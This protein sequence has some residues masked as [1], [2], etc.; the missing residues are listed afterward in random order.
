MGKTILVTGKEGFLGNEISQHFLNQGCQVAA[1]VPPRKESF[2]SVDQD[3]RLLQ[4]PWTRRSAVAAKNFVLRTLQEFES[5]DEAWIVVTPERESFGIAELAPL[6]LDEGLDGTVKG[7]LYLVRELLQRQA[8]HP[9][10]VLRFVFY[11]EDPSTLPPLAAL[12]YQ[13]LRGM[14]TAL[15]TQARKRSLTVWAYETLVPRTEEYLA[16]ILTSKTPQPGRWNV[17]GEKKTLMNSLFTKK[18]GP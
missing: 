9:H 13:G 14:V 3:H 7:T 18:E 2:P 12:H 16:Y 10:F 8:N 1:S 6:A 5:L 4:F 17:L 15:L 11:D